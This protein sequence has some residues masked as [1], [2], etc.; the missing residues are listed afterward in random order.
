MSFIVTVLNARLS[1]CSL[2]TPKSVSGGD[3]RFEATLICGDDTKIKY[4]GSD[5]KEV[6]R[7]YEK[8][9]DIC[10]HVWKERFGKIP[11]KFKNYAFNKADGSTTRDEYT[12]KD[13]E[14]WPG[15]DADTHYITAYKYE[16]RCPPGGITVLDQLK[17]PI[18][19][20]N[21]TI[22]S[23][24]Y[25][26]AVIDVYAF[27]RD[28]GRGVTASLEGVQLLK[29]GEPFGAEP[30]DAASMFEAEEIESLDEDDVADLL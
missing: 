7:P 10:D 12:N 9:S 18:K 28:D 21:G 25:V 27:N 8:M 19:K 6:V 16:A 14:H 26:N 4:T 30:I 24:C 2:F 11:A 3:P 22:F 1:F 17:Q 15:F 13:G 20:N 5:G 23:G 29:R